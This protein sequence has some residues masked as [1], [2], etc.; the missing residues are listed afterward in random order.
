MRALFMDFPNDPKVADLRDEYLFGPAILVAPVHEQG[1]T[2][3]E[4]YLPAGVDWYNFW[5]GERS[6]GGQTLTVDAPI[7]R[8]P[9]FVRAGSIIPLGVPVRSTADPQPI[10]KVRVYPGADGD[11]ALYDDDGRTYA[12]ESGG[13]TETALHWDDKQRQLSPHPEWAEVVGR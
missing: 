12:Y 5:T 7:D 3:R 8:L 6:R 13:F 10:A 2:T 4:V 9:L 1:A 11:F